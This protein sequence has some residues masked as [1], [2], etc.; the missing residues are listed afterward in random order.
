LGDGVGVEGEHRRTLRKGGRAGM[1]RG[2]F[3][4]TFIVVSKT[5]SGMHPDEIATL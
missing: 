3:G 5:H 2:G 4:G 1:K